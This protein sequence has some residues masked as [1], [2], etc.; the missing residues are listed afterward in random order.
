MNRLEEYHFEVQIKK[1]GE[2]RTTIK[3]EKTL[4]PNNLEEWMR[5]TFIEFNHITPINTD[6]NVEAYLH[7]SISGTWMNMASYYGSEKR[8]V[9]H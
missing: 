5:D 2:K 1:V 7:N 3:S 6:I 4:Q 8:F 9:K